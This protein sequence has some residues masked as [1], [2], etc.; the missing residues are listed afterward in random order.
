MTIKVFSEWFC[1]CM[2]KDCNFKKKADTR[3]EVEDEAIAHIEEW[4]EV[5]KDRSNITHR[6]QIFEQTFVAEDWH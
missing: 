1:Y 2:F 3:R 5:K 4:G 6:V